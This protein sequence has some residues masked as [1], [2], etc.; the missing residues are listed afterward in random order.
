MLIMFLNTSFRFLC[1]LND[2]KTLQKYN[3]Q[4]TE[5]TKDNNCHKRF[6]AATSTQR[7]VM[8]LADCQK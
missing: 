8:S 7:V 2:V 5:T 6:H 3:K 1:K 4:Y